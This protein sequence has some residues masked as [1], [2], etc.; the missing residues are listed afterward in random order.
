MTQPQAI[1]AADA[2]CRRVGALKLFDAGDVQANGFQVVADDAPC[3]TYTETGSSYMGFAVSALL[4]QP[5]ADARRYAVAFTGDGS[6]M[7]N[8]QVLV[9][10]IEHGVHGTILLM[11]NRRMAAISSLQ[12]AQY[13]VDWRTSDAVAVDY[14]ALARAVSGVVAI[15]GGVSPETL[16]EA[17]A[18]ARGHAGLSLVSV[19]VYH[20]PDPEGGMGAY[21]QWNVGSWCADVQARYT[22]TLI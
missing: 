18:R 14:L 7:M 12:Q 16:T 6:F 8:P 1:A 4:A 5:L 13:G 19:P 17:L 21:G 22:S 11:D 3:E 15:D 10:G 9:D 2:F 20:G